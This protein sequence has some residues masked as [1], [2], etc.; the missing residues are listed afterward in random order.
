MTIITNEDEHRCTPGSGVRN[1]GLT[2]AFF[3]DI[4]LR[5]RLSD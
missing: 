5:I 3:S 1:S 2:Y 4:P